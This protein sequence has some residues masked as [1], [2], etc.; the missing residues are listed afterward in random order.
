MQGFVEIL[1]PYLQDD[2]GV[3]INPDTGEET[4][5]PAILLADNEVPKST[6]P[7][8]LFSYQGSQNGYVTNR[9][10]YEE[11]N[12]D[13]DPQD[14][15]SEEKLYFIQR[16]NH[17]E[18]SMTITAE[19]GSVTEVL[20][21]N[22]LSANALLRKI[23]TLLQRDSVRKELN[24][25][26]ECGI[27]Y[28]GTEIPV[29]TLEGVTRTD[30]SSLLLSNLTYLEIDQQQVVGTIDHIKTYGELARVDETDPDPIP[31]DNEIDYP[32]P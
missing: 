25:L 23:R 13:Y 16:E 15:E 32:L 11:D 28:I 1:T 7:R 12:P 3:L 6:L 4:T 29:R 27:G 20:T 18:W 2:V 31:V 24:D 5:V 14:P 22:R 17:I 8:L 10:A 26:I 9:F 21:G 30:A 19:S